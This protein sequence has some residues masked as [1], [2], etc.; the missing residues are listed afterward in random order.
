LALLCPVLLLLLRL[1]LPLPHLGRLSLLKR[2]F[3]FL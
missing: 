1:P 3:L 2:Q